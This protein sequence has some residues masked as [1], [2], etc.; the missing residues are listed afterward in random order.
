VLA[1]LDRHARVVSRRVFE[2]YTAWVVY[3]GVMEA[4][5]R[6]LTNKYSGVAAVAS[7][8]A[9]PVPALDELIVVPL[10][11]RLIRR[12]AEERSV[13]VKS[14]PWVQL[15][16]VIWYGAVARLVGNFSVGFVPVVGMFS[17]AITAIALTEYLAR[18]LDDVLAHPDRPPPE[19]TLE[20]L[21]ELFRV[22]VEKQQQ[23]QTTT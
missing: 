3:S 13:P 10:H 9:Q 8:L 18:Y 19:V 7:F 16:R 14:L 4:E 1:N 5:T 6:R 11:Y 22:A 20:S 2:R 15:R 23:A 21:K 12:M 17:N